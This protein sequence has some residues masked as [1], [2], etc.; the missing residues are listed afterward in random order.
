MKSEKYLLDVEGNIYIFDDGNMLEGH[1]LKDYASGEAIPYDDTKIILYDDKLIYEMPSDKARNHIAGKRKLSEILDD[2]SALSPEDITDDELSAIAPVIYKIYEE[3]LMVLC[4]KEGEDVRL[5]QVSAVAGA[6]LKP[7]GRK[8][9]V[10]R[11]EAGKSGVSQVKE[12]VKQVAA[13]AKAE[14]AQ[15][16]SFQA[17]TKEEHK[18]ESFFSNIKNLSKKIAWNNFSQVKSNNS[19]EAGNG[20]GGWGD[21]IKKCDVETEGKGF[22]LSDEYDLNTPAVAEEVKLKTINDCDLTADDKNILN[23]LKVDLM[24]PG[25]KMTLSGKNLLKFGIGE[26]QIAKLQAGKGFNIEISLERDKKDPNKFVLT[27]GSGE[28][29]LLSGDVAKSAAGGAGAKGEANLETGT[30]WSFDLD[31]S[32]KDEAK[33]MAGFLAHAGLSAM[34]DQISSLAPVGN[35]MTKLEVLGIE[36]IPGVN[37]PGEPVDFIK[38][39]FKSVEF[40]G[41]AGSNFSAGVAMVVGQEASIVDKLK[42]GGKLEI[43]DKGGYTFT[44]GLSK[45]GSISLDNL[46]KGDFDSK[47]PGLEIEGTLSKTDASLTGKLSL[48]EVMTLN[49][50]GSSQ[51]DTVF[52]INAEGEKNFGDLMN[53]GAELELSTS[54]SNLIKT[55][56]PD[57]GTE[58]KSAIDNKNYDDAKKIFQEK[59]MDNLLNPS[60][61]VDSKLRTFERFD[62]TGESGLGYTNVKGAGVKIE[63]TFEREIPTSSFEGKAR[64]DKNGI[65]FSASGETMDWNSFAGLL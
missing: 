16:D 35:I 65:S 25:E 24:K 29:S 40:D 42:G 64:L 31:L 5:Y 59:V 15:K 52:K 39:H 56:P 14:V 4:E 3:E 41:G 38:N 32:K 21:E 43:N 23:S 18:D 49:K 13:E 30:K 28:K 11:A 61:E 1:I 37:I 54:L 44:T 60:V 50:D 47:F 27:T 51:S 48:E 26:E 12:N 63:S 2:I 36:Q 57:V 62:T 9:T 22:N 55:L 45:E 53:K 58:L 8:Q 33:N 46:I 19:R 34:S 10:A 7:A 6:S 17:K 20:G